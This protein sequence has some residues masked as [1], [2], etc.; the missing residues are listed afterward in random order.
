[1]AGPCHNVIVHSSI[2]TE[3]D[4]NH[5]KALRTI[6]QDCTDEQIIAEIALREENKQ[7]KMI[8]ESITK[9]YRFEKIIGKG[10]SGVV[11]LVVNRNTGKEYACKVVQRNKMN[12]AKSLNIEIKIMNIVNHRNVVALTEL[13]ES[14]KCRWFV[15]ELTTSGGLREL[16]SNFDHLSEIT[17]CKLMRQ[18]LEGV[19]YLH[20]QGIVHRDLK[21]DNILFNGDLKTGEIKIADFGL[22]ALVTPGTGGYHAT[23][24]VKRKAYV[25]LTEPWGT[26]TIFGHL[27]SLYLLVQITCTL[28]L[29]F[30]V[31]LS[32]INFTHAVTHCSPELIFKRA[33]GPQTDLW[34]VGCTMY[35][36]LTGDPAFSR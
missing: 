14:P 22:S 28:V 21:V 2:S 20:N 4:T 12:D 10:S 11:H 7:H 16:L 1:M 8:N 34:A 18:L 26:G 23:D 33:Y 30:E 17:V 32:M 6:L 3:L 13:F 27:P 9:K 35:E 5:E 29:K 31:T 36:M 24:S 15:M 19:H 25:G